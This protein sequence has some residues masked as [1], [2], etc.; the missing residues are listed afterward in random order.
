MY[1]IV[2]TILCGPQNDYHNISLTSVLIIEVVV[3]YVHTQHG[4][5]DHHKAVQVTAYRKVETTVH[6]MF[7]LKRET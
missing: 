3:Q 1:N 4:N 6:A 5:H 2:Y 7:E